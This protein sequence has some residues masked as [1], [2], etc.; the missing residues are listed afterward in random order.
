[1]GFQ[2]GFG[3]FEKKVYLDVRKSKQ[4]DFNISIIALLESQLLKNNRHND[5]QPNIMK[6]KKLNLNS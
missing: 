4:I 5:K 3:F 1:M 2:G 6:I